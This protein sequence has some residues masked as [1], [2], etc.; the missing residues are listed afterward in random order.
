MIGGWLS[1]LLGGKGGEDEKDI[2][3]EIKRLREEI[4]S[5]QEDLEQRLSDIE[6]WTEEKD[7]HIEKN[8]Q[9][10]EHLIE[11]IAH[12][13]ESD[14]EQVKNAM[15]EELAAYLA[16]I[17][18]RLAKLEKHSTPPKKSVEPA[19]SSSKRPSKRLVDEDGRT[20]TVVE[21]AEGAKAG[22]ELWKQATPAQ[23]S[24]LQTM[25]D[26]GYPM[27]YKELAEEVGRSVSTVKNHINNLKSAGFD[28]KEDS[29][30]NNAKKYMI[31]DRVKAF[32]TLRLNE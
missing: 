14:E 18:E 12:T 27:S 23:R 9:A 24:I 16:D 20:S 3:T 6:E 21:T 13:L 8:A 31:D 7:E 28:F 30:H 5:Q 11:A 22:E 25:Y 26:A 1:R 10:V 17:E 32:L 19:T 15:P 29:G 2:S 4:G